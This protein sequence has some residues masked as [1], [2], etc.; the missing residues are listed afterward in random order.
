MMTFKS[1]TCFSKKTGKPLTEYMSRYEA[2]EGADYAN[3][4]YGNSLSSYQCNVCGGWH[5]SPKVRQTPSIKCPECTDS[6]GYSKALYLTYESALN[7]ASILYEERGVMLSVYECP[8]Y[9]GWHLTK[10]N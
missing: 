1:K 7:R 5:L 6:N 2:D 4:T 9:E 8:H 10:S 3:K